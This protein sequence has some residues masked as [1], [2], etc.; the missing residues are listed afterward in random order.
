MNLLNLTL[1]IDHLPSLVISYTENSISARNNKSHQRS[2]SQSSIKTED[3]SLKQSR[4]HS[5]SK[6]FEDG[7]S[8]KSNDDDTSK[9][10]KKPRRP[11]GRVGPPVVSKAPTRG[12]LKT[13]SK[14]AKYDKSNNESDTKRVSSDNTAT[15]SNGN[16]YQEYSDDEPQKN[17]KY[18]KYR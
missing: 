5:T 18:H 2:N 14:Y 7:L 15:T 8:V 13:K 11:Q 4:D 9:K 17:N 16:V 12:I 1:L 6:S 3:E 10:S